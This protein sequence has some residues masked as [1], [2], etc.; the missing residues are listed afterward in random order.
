[1]LDQWAHLQ[2]VEIDFFRPGKPTNNVFREAFNGRLR[3]EC[4]NASWFLSMA[5]AI[6]R[7]EEWRCHSNND[8]P[9]TSLGNLTRNEFARQTHP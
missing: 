1:M 6:D 8:K 7:L 9:H 5:D 4:L 3:V 2:D